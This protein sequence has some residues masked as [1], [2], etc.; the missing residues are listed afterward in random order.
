MKHKWL[1]LLSILFFLLTGCQSV[2]DFLQIGPK[3]QEAEAEA[4]STGQVAASV[5]EVLNRLPV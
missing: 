2:K 1:T 3:N 5:D 4:G